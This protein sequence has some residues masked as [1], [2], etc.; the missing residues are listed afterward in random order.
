MAPTVGSSS[1]SS[2]EPT[3]TSSRAVKIPHRNTLS[4][5]QAPGQSPRIREKGH[6]TSSRAEARL[7]RGSSSDS[8]SPASYSTKASASEHATAGPSSSSSSSCSS[9]FENSLY[10]P[11]SSISS[12]KLKAKSTTASPLNTLIPPHPSPLGPSM[13][14]STSYRS[15][16]LN[17][18]FD[19]TSGSPPHLITYTKTGQGFTWNEELFLPSYMM[20][21]YEAGGGRRR[22]RRYEDDDTAG[23]DNEVVEIAEIFVSDEE[24]RNM[25]P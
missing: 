20:G 9:S 6:K 2:S 12:S 8:S 18:D 1:S 24:A 11:A 19:G 7:A 5:E 4:E 22:R 14:S 3:A 21:R 15:I 25:M 17:S 16:N 23:G 10:D 13:A